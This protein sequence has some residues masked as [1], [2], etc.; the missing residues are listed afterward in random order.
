MFFVWVFFGRTPVSRFFLETMIVS[1]YCLKFLF[2]KNCSHCIKDALVKN[3]MSIW[4]CN[5]CYL[6]L[7]SKSFFMSVS[8]WNFILKSMKVYFAKVGNISQIYLFFSWSFKF[9]YPSIYVQVGFVV[10][11]VAVVCPSVYCCFVIVL[12]CLHKAAFFYF[13]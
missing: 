5:C 10:C 6:F 1:R 12:V 8:R 13:F 4:G 11:C 7:D 9:F 3:N 2:S